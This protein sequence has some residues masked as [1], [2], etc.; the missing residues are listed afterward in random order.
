MTMYDSITPF[1]PN[2]FNEFQWCTVVGSSLYIMVMTHEN[3]WLNG[4]LGMIRHNS[5]N[6]FNEFQW[7]TV[8]GSSL[9]I[10]VM[11]HE[12]HWLNGELGT[13]RHK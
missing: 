9:Y 10:M 6:S 8:V 11:T 12:N 4:E 5:P 3:H 1:S 7:C 13:I 2:S